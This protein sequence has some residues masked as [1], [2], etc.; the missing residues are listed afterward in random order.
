MLVIRY[1]KLMVRLSCRVMPGIVR[2]PGDSCRIIALGVLEFSGLHLSFATYFGQIRGVRIL[3]RNYLHSIRAAR[4][5][6]V[7]N[8]DSISGQVDEKRR[9]I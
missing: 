3:D 6:R 1:T 2:T 8:S 4:P 9:P 7:L 5:Q